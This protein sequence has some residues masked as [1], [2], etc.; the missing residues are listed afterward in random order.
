[1]THFP[2]PDTPQPP[3]KMCPYPCRESTI[4]TLRQITT[5]AASK[6]SKI[7]L[8]YLPH[9]TE[10]YYTYIKQNRALFYETHDPDNDNF[11]WSKELNQI[12]NELGI[13]FADPRP[14]LITAAA[15]TPFL[16]RNINDAH[17]S[18]HGHD[19]FARFLYKY[20]DN[21]K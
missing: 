20:V 16:Y 17:L 10:V 12:S 18:A 11:G 19:V 13:E 7:I 21:P 1:K 2:L 6:N 8:T 4:S 14:F 15:Q 5:L 9:P 3:Q